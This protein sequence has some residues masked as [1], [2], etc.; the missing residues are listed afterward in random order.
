LATIGAPALVALEDRSAHM[1]QQFHPDILL[2]E[3][4]KPTPARDITPYGDRQPE[5]FI[6]EYS[7]G[8]AIDDV[9]PRRSS[10]V[11]VRFHDPG[12]QHDRQFEALSIA[13]ADDAGAG[14]ISGFNSIPY[15]RIDS[16]IAATRQM[17]DKW[18]AAG[19]QTVHLELA[20]YDTPAHRDRVI[21]KLQGT[22]TSLGMSHSEFVALIPGGSDLSQDMCELGDRLGLD[23]VCI[24][25]D[26]WAA[27]ATRGDP[28]IE[29]RALM[30]GCL[31]AGTR[32]ANGIPV[33]P[34]EIDAR[35]T[36]SAPPLPLHAKR[37]H[38][39]IISCASP[40]LDT[41]VAAVGLGDT[42]TGGCLLVLGQHVSIRNHTV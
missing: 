28:D 23:R 34:R 11:I 7:A 18:R 13:L 17:T 22:V 32:A 2:A 19:L 40:H 39:S 3:N 33:P 24:H 29:Q 27:S 5:I 31:L 8:R 16:E 30:M 20:G 36:F 35:A 37:G 26:H 4:G 14:L 15:E 12:L 10:R 6:V 42:F 25:A 41:P 21:A 9:M 1:L 38:W